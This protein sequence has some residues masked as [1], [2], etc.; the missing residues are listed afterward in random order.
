MVCGRG[1]RSA[2]RRPPPAAPWSW[3]TSWPTP[4]CSRP[5]KVVVASGRAG[6]R[7]GGRSSGSRTSASAMSCGRAWDYGSLCQKQ[8]IGRLLFRQF[9]E[10]R[11][12]LLR[13][14]RFLDA[15]A[16]YE[17][18]PD[19]KRKEMGEE[20]IRR[21]LEQE[22]PDF[23]PEVGQPHAR[24][25]LQD[26]QKSPCKDLFSSCLH[27]LH[28]YLSGDPFVDYRD[29]MYFDRFL[30]WK[31]LE[32]QS[33]T[34]DTFRQY[35]ILGKG[36]FGEVC[37]CQVRA[38]GKMYAC[39]K[40]E[41]KRIKKRK[42]EAMALNE[43]QILEKV[44]SRFVVSLAY[45][46]ETKDALC[47][48]LTI[49]NGGDLKFHIYNMGNPGFEDERVVFYAAEICC[50]LQHLH[51][52][53]IVYRDLKPENILLDDDGHIRISDLGLAIKIPE[54]ETIRGRV[55]T[56][57]YMAP[58]V[59]SN[60]RYAFSPDWWG[61]GCLVYEM[62]E[63]Q[64]PFRARKERVKREEVEKRVREEPELYSDKFSE[65][66]RAICTMDHQLQA[67]GSRHHDTLL[68]AGPPGGLLQGRAGHRAVLDSE[69]RQ[70]GPNRQRFLR[71][72]RHRQRL[73]PLAER[74]DRDRV[75]QGP[76]RVRPQRD[77][78]PRPGL[79]AAARAPQAQPSA[80]ALPAPPQRHLLG[81]PG[82]CWD[83]NP[84]PDA[85]GTARRWCRPRCRGRAAVPSPRSS[86]AT[87][88]PRATSGGD[89]EVT[90]GAGTRGAG[91][92]S[93]AR[94]RA[95][96]GTPESRLHGAAAPVGE[97]E[98]GCGGDFPQPRRGRGAVLGCSGTVPGWQHPSAGVLKAERPE[99]RGRDT[100]PPQTPARRRH[101]PAARGS[102]R[103]REMLPATFKLCAAISYQN[104][105]NMTGL[106]RQAAVAIS[107]ELSKLACRG[108]GPSTWVNQVR[109]R[110][111]LLSSRLEEKPF[112]EVEMSYIRQGE[113]ALQKSLNI[114][115]DQ[116][117]WKTETVLGNGDRVLSKVLPDV[118]KVFRLEVVVEQPLA[119]LYGELVDNMEQMGD[120]NPSVQQVK[121][122]QKIGKDTV[123]THEKAAATPGN[124]VGPRDFVSV[125]CSKRRGSTCVLAG[126]ATTH[127]AMPEQEGVVRAENGP[128][129][130]LLRPLPGSPS[131]TRLTWL[132]SIDLKGWLP[133]TVVNQVLAQT[134]VD[135][136]N[137]LRQRLAR[138]PAAALPEGCNG[139][140]QTQVN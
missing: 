114:L 98:R 13:C 86:T 113:E 72:V 75:L 97:R 43:K 116:E 111:S 9:C 81:A 59:I 1:G 135:F 91:G 62:I 121:I 37:A 16:D 109:R 127:G 23:L 67:P 53:G 35:R 19:E 76:Q 6:A 54:G 131:H 101:P 11:P 99:G 74:D 15:V 139:A 94:A 106:R 31:Y 25:C 68:R 26:L 120:W 21:F 88:G 108:A 5:A 105:R 85:C 132:L 56:V 3:R 134:Q 58:E 52:E 40:L 140:R 133:K 39:K 45:A 112:S 28:E 32:R 80:A 46:Y 29:S 51:Q 38:T 119:A 64:S 90:S 33:V 57:G 78:L 138:P 47:L 7:S 66:A 65:D 24:R 123:I 14:I 103:P 104:L 125:R 129:C 136:A 102:L 69:G 8:P 87:A 77:P 95:A 18:S 122:L 130:M 79:E 60:E 2:A 128:T 17:L 73:H 49:M 93:P 41:K 42:G 126:V 115:G 55:G 20:I 44:N 61:L 27:P 100:R 36:G 70:L 110:S 118:G 10:T 30:Q 92:G 34:K 137:H 117:G 63:G 22:S 50:G 124:V 84:V 89:A 82:R 96:G 12:E 48:V 71:Q 83:P 107:Q 4:S